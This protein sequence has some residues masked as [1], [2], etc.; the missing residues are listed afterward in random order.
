[1]FDQMGKYFFFLVTLTHMA[2]PKPKSAQYLSV[3][4]RVGVRHCV[5]LYL[6]QVKNM[7]VIYLAETN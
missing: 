5:F 7:F 4:F 2:A 1:M 3:S 6:R